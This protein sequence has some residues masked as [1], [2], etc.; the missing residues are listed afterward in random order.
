MTVFSIKKIPKGYAIRLNVASVSS[1]KFSYV[2]QI[3]IV[4]IET[5]LPELSFNWSP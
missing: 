4:A 2:L 1:I 3:E 5:N